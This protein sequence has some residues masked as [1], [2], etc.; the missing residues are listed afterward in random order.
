MDGPYLTAKLGASLVTL[1]ARV[2]C[3]QCGLA[4]DPGKSRRKVCSDSCKSER[5]RA[6]DKARRPRKTR[7]ELKGLFSR[8]CLWCFAGFDV[9]R[10]HLDS[11]RTSGWFCSRECSF[12]DKK[13]H[14]GPAG[15]RRAWADYAAQF[16]KAQR[17]T[18]LSAVCADCRTPIHAAA[19]RC[20]GCKQR[21]N[22]KASALSYRKKTSVVRECPCCQLAWSA[23]DRAGPRRHCYTEECNTAFELH[24]RAARQEERRKRGGQGHQSRARRYGCARES[25]N[26]LEVLDRDRW[27]C[28]LCGVK[29][30]KAKRGSIDD[31][32][33]ELDHVVPLSKGGPHTRANT[34]C[35]CR[36]CN[37][38]K[39]DTARGQLG[40]TF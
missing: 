7:R 16:E 21:A 35:L 23:I 27:R 5:S 38:L 8:R 15:T 39:S 28:Q 11:G 3:A 13:L 2:K 32:A 9:H 1:C 37:G 25:F 19:V 18:T 34:Q 29:T 10:A 12:A 33:P 22:K 30:P 20:A 4:F 36:R 40:L 14:G 31:D 24:Q 17:V 26:P 6:R